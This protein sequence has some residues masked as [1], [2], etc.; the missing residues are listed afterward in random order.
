MSR[1]VDEKA[2]E[3][4]VLD[5][6]SKYLEICIKAADAINIDSSKEIAYRLDC[7]VNRISYDRMLL[8]LQLFTQ[9]AT[10]S[11][12]QQFF[13]S[14]LVKDLLLYS[15]P[16]SIIRLHR[17]PGGLRLALPEIDIITRTDRGNKHSLGNNTRERRDIV[18]TYDAVESITTSTVS[19][20]SSAA[21]VM[22]V[23]AALKAAPFA[24]SLQTNLPN[25]ETIPDI[26]QQLE[27]LERQPPTAYSMIPPPSSSSF[28][29]LSQ[30]VYEPVF[31]TNTRLQ[32]MLRL[33]TQS[34]TSPHVFSAQDIKL[35]L[36]AVEQTLHRGHLAELN[37]SQWE[38]IQRAMERPLSLIQGPPGTGKTKTACALVLTLFEC[39]QQRLRDGGERAKGMKVSKVLACAHS[40]VATDNLLQGL[41]DLKSSLKLVRLGRPVNIRSS[42]WNHTLDALLQQDPRWQES[43]RLLDEAMQLFAA[44]K[45]QSGAARPA[46]GEAQRELGFARNHHEQVELKCS[47]DILRQADVV[48][49]TCIGVGADTLRSFAAAEAVKFGSVV[50]DEAAQC[51]EAATLPPLMHGCERLVLVGDQNQLPPVV[52]SPSALQK[53]LGVSLFSR[54]IAGGL[55][56]LLLNQQYRMHPAIAAFPSSQFYGGRLLSD[57]VSPIA[58]PAPSGL[59][60]PNPAIPVFFI[61][62]SPFTIKIKNDSNDVG[63]GDVRHIHSEEQLSESVRNMPPSVPV[64]GG[65]ESMSDSA[66]ASYLNEKE[67]DVVESLVEQLLGDAA[68]RKSHIGVVSPYN[69]QVRR[70]SQRFKDRGWQ[71]QQQEVVR[72]DGENGD[73]ADFGLVSQI[74]AATLSEPSPANA[75]TPPSKSFIRRRGRES[76]SSEI[77]SMNSTIGRTSREPK[78]YWPSSNFTVSSKLQSPLSYLPQTTTTGST[79]PSTRPGLSIDEGLEDADKEEE[80]QEEVEVKSVD[81][82]QGREKEI[83]VF[84]AVRSNRQ[85]RVGFLGDWRRLNVAITRARSGLVVVG[86]RSTLQNDRNWRA[87]IAWCES[88][89]CYQEHTLSNPE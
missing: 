82:F 27:Q 23:A 75:W 19:S 8:A 43:R 13:V 12:G 72:E 60:W 33:P 37:P 20:T 30:A 35:A 55:A 1:V 26:K 69:A 89:G 46:F 6:R 76:N 68:N 21:L 10:D 61:N 5:R 58:R 77:S 51:M 47:H 32:E 83:I 42:L 62:V 2:V 36:N 22:T 9:S 16:N 11:G 53:G 34:S 17:S 44:C 84:S 14:K 56:P 64:S 79:G 52:M 66:Q 7:F 85:G 80:E 39:K 15:Y 88:S 74:G 38:A 40:N 25:T 70:L 86:D 18:T 45:K 78:D 67:A 41:L 24:T 63:D 73:L 57:H 59:R 71:T 65:F 31:R 54:L 50:V 81:G 28:S 48:V 29:A 4:M 49:S 3:G 87:F